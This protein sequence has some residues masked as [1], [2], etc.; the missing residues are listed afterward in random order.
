MKLKWTNM[1]RV[2]IVLVAT[3]AAITSSL[4]TQQT[5]L[6][7]VFSLDDSY[8][9]LKTDEVR[10]RY[11]KSTLN[12]RF[13]LDLMSDFGVRFTLKTGLRY[14]K[15]GYTTNDVDAHWPS[16][17]ENGM[18]VPDPIL[19]YS[20]TIEHSYQYLELP[21][22]IR[23]HI[24]DKKIKLF[25]EGGL[26]INYSLD[27]TWMEVYNFNRF[28]FSSNIGIGAAMA[29]GNAVSVYCMPVYRYHL[30]STLKNASIDEHL[31]SFGLE[32]G[33]STQL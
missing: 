29:L 8:R 12:Y 4:W 23:Y 32:L 18:Y 25:A 30:T 27:K 28:N 7:V 16:E 24:L 9:T 33:I 13:G 11:E 22:D 6:G 5:S 3:Q 2:F 21:L 15:T 10:D 19:P 14:Y 31:Y 1:K 20:G 17:S 26:S